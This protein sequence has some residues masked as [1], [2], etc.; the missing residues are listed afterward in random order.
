MCASCG[1]DPSASVRRERR[2][3][4]LR[5]CICYLASF[6][7]P[8]VRSECAVPSNAVE[9]PG[10][11]ARDVTRHR[12][13]RAGTA[14]NKRKPDET[15]RRVPSAARVK[16]YI[17]SISR[18]YAQPPCTRPGQVSLSSSSS[19]PQHPERTS[20]R[21]N[22]ATSWRKCKA[23]HPSPTRGAERGWRCRRRGVGRWGRRRSATAVT[24]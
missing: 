21:Q 18:A 1:C 8:E 24:R 11:G 20:H 2:P 17:L 19:S 12:P 3:A 22:S 9:S 16:K 13:R 23:L 14:A 6:E 5:M 7:V 4:S 10:R 15:L